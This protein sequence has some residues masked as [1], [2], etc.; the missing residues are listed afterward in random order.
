MC[1]IGWNKCDN[2]YCLTSKRISLARK[3]VDFGSDDKLM[4]QIAVAC[5]TGFGLMPVEL[6]T[7]LS[8]LKAL[9]M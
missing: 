5:L 6:M 3:N 4:F 8:V 7:A 1:V 9:L 2:M